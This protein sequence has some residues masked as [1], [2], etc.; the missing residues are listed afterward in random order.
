MQCQETCR[1]ATDTLNLPDEGGM[2]GCKC[3][4]KGTKSIQNICPLLPLLWL[5]A[6][7]LGNQ[8]HNIQ[9]PLVCPKNVWPVT[10]GGQT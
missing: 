9:L 6:F 1:M 2:Q 7:S 5:N 10:Q 4:C 3:K 8:I